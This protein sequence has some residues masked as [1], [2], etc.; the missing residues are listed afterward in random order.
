MPGLQGWLATPAG[1]YVLAWEQ[2]QLDQIVADVFGYHALQL[3]LPAV[4]ALGTNRMQ[5]RWLALDQAAA[6][7]GEASGAMARMAVVT[8]FAALPWPENS[9]DL[10]VLPHA[11]ELNADPHAVLREVARVLVPEGRVVICS[12][13]P[14]SLW[15]LRQWRAQLYRRLGVDEPSLRG[16]GGLIG[17]WRLRDWLRLLDLDIESERFGC[18]RPAMRNERWLARLAWMDR[19]GGRWW[20][21]FGA[22]HV[23]VAVKRVRGMMLMEPVWKKARAARAAAAPVANRARSERASMEEIS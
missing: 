7:A 22:V 1:Q 11:L 17:F 5:H 13:N 3:G 19:A 16:A 23:V 8:D 10:V 21:I 20:P 6:P 9:L 4:D 12:M 15:G 14:A 2:A 18:Y